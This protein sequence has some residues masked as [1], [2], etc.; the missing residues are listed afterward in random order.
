MIK[1][2][3]FDTNQR[4]VTVVLVAVLMVVFLGLAA[5]AV[6][7]SH[8][9]VVRNELQNAADAGALAGPGCVRC[10]RFISA[11]VNSISL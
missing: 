1:Y 4:G 11:F 8:L 2:L 6:D 9:Y 7:I 3:R 5:L 10:T